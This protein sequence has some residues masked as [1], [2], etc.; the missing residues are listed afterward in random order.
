[1]G[2][3]DAAYL[4]AQRGVGGKQGIRQGNQA[5]AV[6]NRVGR[7][8]RVSIPRGI[9]GS[10]RAEILADR[11]LGILVGKRGSAGDPIGQQLRTVGRRPERHVW[12]HVPV[13]ARNLGLHARSARQEAEPRLG[14]GHYADAA[15][16]Q[17]LPEPFVIAEQEEAVLPERSA[18][19][20]A[21]L[22]PPE[23]RHERL[24]QNIARVQGA[25]AQKLE[26]AAMR[27]V[28]SRLGDHVDL[29]AGSLSVFDGIGIREDVE[30]P[31][32]IDSQQLSTHSARRNRKLTRSGIFNAVQQE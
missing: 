14:V 31:H 28:A 18:Q 27:G 22:I 2:L 30:L 12:Q 32:R 26:Y 24:I 7:R 20:A 19:R 29:R 1:M 15:D 25:V 6:V 21:E 11:L 23:G 5:I 9:V 13:Q 3:V 16:R 10:Q 17:A 4:H 8:E